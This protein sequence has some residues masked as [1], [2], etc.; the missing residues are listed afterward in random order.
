MK[1]RLFL[2]VGGLFL[3]I[4]SV[5]GQ[6]NLEV[7]DITTQRDVFSGKDTEAGIVISCPS[8]IKLTI[9][10]SHDKVVDVYNVEDKGEE[11]F[12]YMRFETGRRYRGRKLTVRADGYAP[13]SIMAELNPKELKRY[14]LIDPDVEFVYGCYYEYRKR[15]TEYFQQAMYVEAKEQY[16]IAQA[17]SD[18]PENSGLDNLIAGIDSITVYREKAD[19]AFDLLDYET[20]K[21]YYGR[22]VSLNP[23]DENASQKV[24]ECSRNFDIDCNKYFDS[25]EA[26]REEGDYEKAME[27]YQRV[28]DGNCPN[29][30]KASQQ[31]KLLRKEVNSR[32][33]RA[34]VYVY[35]YSKSAPI[36]LG[37]GTYN[38]NKVGGYFSLSFHSDLFKALQK[39][40]NEVKDAEL[41]LSFGWTL[42]KWEKV[43]VW[44]FFGVGYTGA[45]EF[46]DSDGNRYIEPEEDSTQPDQSGDNSGS[47]GE[48]EDN[49]TFKLYSA[50]SPEVGLLGKIG[51]VVLRYTFQYRFSVSKEYEDK[52]SK[53]RHAFGIGFCF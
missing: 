5:F 20:A 26:Y 24:F 11:T 22:I 25:A 16:A 8:N 38:K 36:G 41:N 52:I 4:A 47:Y 45:G 42:N 10:S 44:V 50:I 33:Q 2:L 34:R 3:A 49:P 51:P 21:D 1:K 19:E 18:C 7:K 9:E 31:L 15:G 23:S 27:L 39:S 48:E 35:E 14:Q 29:A 43:P 37:T 46:V 30:I 13:V 28:V 6:R 17:C 40:Y 53:T 32:K 12:Y